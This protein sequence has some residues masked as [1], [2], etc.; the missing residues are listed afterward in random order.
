[1]EDITIPNDELHLRMWADLRARDDARMLA[2][3][4]VDEAALLYF[5]LGLS[6]AAVLHAIRLNQAEWLARLARSN[7]RRDAISAAVVHAL[8]KEWATG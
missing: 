2:E 4:A 1:M 6:V 5:G 8:R 3:E 7:D